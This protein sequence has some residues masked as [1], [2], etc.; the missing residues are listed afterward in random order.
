MQPLLPERRHPG[1]KI[2]SISYNPSAQKHH[3]PKAYR[4]TSLNKSSINTKTSKKTPSKFH[5][6]SRKQSIV[7][8]KSRKENTNNKYSK[9]KGSNKKGIKFDNKGYG[10]SLRNSYYLMHHKQM[11]YDNLKK[12]NMEFENTYKKNTMDTDEQMDKIYQG[13]GGIDRDV[14]MRGMS[15]QSRRRYC[16][17]GHNSDKKGR[18]KPVEMSYNIINSEMK[19]LSKKKVINQEDQ[20]FKEELDHKMMLKEARNNQM[21]SNI[22]VGIL[23]KEI[24]KN[25]K[26][27]KRT[28]MKLIQVEQGKDFPKKSHFENT[29]NKTNRSSKKTNE[30]EMTSSKLMNINRELQ[31]PPTRIH[32]DHEVLLL[33]PK[34]KA[35]R[36]N[37]LHHG[38]NNEEEYLNS[39]LTKKLKTET[40]GKTHAEIKKVSLNNRD[41]NLFK[42][43]QDKIEKEKLNMMTRKVEDKTFIR[44]VLG[45]IG[46]SY[47]A[48]DFFDKEGVLNNQNPSTMA[49]EL[50]ESI[51][52][53]K[54]FEKLQ[55]N[56]EVNYFGD[57][58]PNHMII[59]TD[60]FKESLKFD[61]I[62]QRPAIN[63][64]NLKHTQNNM[65]QYL[66][67]VLKGG[68]N[69]F[70]YEQPTDQENG[71]IKNVFSYLETLKN[72]F[73]LQ[74]TLMKKNNIHNDYSGK[75]FFNLDKLI[76]FQKL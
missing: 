54:K 42:N 30:E 58:K 28:H 19:N 23:R 35:N 65:N 75:I 18:G 48:D 22:T 31:R 47:M 2:S 39:V 4:K 61:K 50:F 55:K 49:K 17:E 15:N 45:T 60:N 66:H 14:Y 56:E 12:D 41:T 11:F 7:S 25:L 67:S 20:K 21:V 29:K 59:Q 52:L 62:P 51:K 71:S 32:Q 5:R 64:V 69:G 8:Y 9:T 10:R 13:Q 43:Q 63:S 70:Y 38:L 37:I 44:G 33:N 24:E 34:A 16:E 76:D 27:L 72:T 1:I 26:E 3:H 36:E 68:N 74:D 46:K 73:N 6:S 40:Q 57:S 53:K